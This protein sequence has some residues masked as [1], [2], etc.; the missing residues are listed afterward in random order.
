[1][2]TQSFN[3]Y[4]ESD[5]NTW[6][7]VA[8][9]PMDRLSVFEDWTA[10]PRMRSQRYKISCVDTCNNESGQSFYH[11]TLHLTSTYGDQPDEVRLMWN[12]YEGTEYAEYII[13][14]GPTPEEMTELTRVPRDVQTYVVGGVLDT[15]YYRIG[16]T[17]PAACVPTSDLKAGTGPYTHSLSNLDDNRKLITNLTEPV[18]ILEVRAYP[19]PFYD[20]TRIEFPNPD[21]SDYTLAVFNMAGQKVREV[22]QIRDSGII[23]EREDLKTGFFVFQ[24][25]GEN[26][27]YWGKFIVR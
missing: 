8:N 24:L 12:Q 10:D 17:L 13:Y 21:R 4:R 22:R 18:S 9:I 19:N 14:S 25:K 6:E 3:I 2:G 11:N 16:I 26:N 15:L 5:S 27:T 7:Y 23:L 20:K 1:M